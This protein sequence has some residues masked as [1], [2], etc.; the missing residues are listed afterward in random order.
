MPDG[1]V[2]PVSEHRT[3]EIDALP[4][5]DLSLAIKRQVVSIFGNRHLGDGSFG[6]NATFY[7]PRRGRGPDNDLLTGSTGILWAAHHQHTELGDT[8]SSFSLTSSPIRCRS[9]RQQGPAWSLISTTISMRGMGWQ[10]TYIC[11]PLGDLRRSGRAVENC[12]CSS[13]PAASTCS[14]SARPSRGWSP[15][16][17]SARRPKRWRCN[18]LMI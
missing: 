8:M 3:V 5:V 14:A 15:G 12:S 2:D 17:V 13:S 16:S 10:R 1:T 9:L 18:S 11:A 4:L 6:R 7:R